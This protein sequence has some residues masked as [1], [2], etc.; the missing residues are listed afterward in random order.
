MTQAAID[1]EF[2]ATRGIGNRINALAQAELAV[3]AVDELPADVQER[4]DRAIAAALDE[5]GPHHA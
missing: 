2:H 1:A 5:F 4:L 3:A